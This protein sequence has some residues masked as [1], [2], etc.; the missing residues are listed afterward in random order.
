[1]NYKDLPAVI[2]EKLFMSHQH[3]ENGFIVYPEK[4]VVECIGLIMSK[5]YLKFKASSWFIHS[6]RELILTPKK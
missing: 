6:E 5:E 1:M 2:R 4:V 3:D